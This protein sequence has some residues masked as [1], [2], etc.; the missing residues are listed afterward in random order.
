MINKSTIN[1]ILGIAG[2][3][4]I[5]YTV[6]LHSKYAK[7]SDR[8]NTAIDDLANATEID[9]SDEIINQ[10]VEKAVNAAVKDSI[11]KAT[12]EA[13]AEVRT[14]IRRKVAE[15]VT[16]EYESV[17]DSVLNE[18]TAAA[19]KIDVAKVQKDVEEKAEKI[20][21][22][23]FEV[24]LSDIVKKFKSD[25]NTAARVCSTIQNMSGGY[26]PSHNVVLKFG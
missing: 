26:D 4:G 24:N 19:A 14:D 23:K 16:K 13:V 20:A 21:L 2:A 15:A 18:I 11:T 9:I 1:T 10:A 17:K 7:V 5:A 6:A 3:A 22:E 12:N 25:W 8:L